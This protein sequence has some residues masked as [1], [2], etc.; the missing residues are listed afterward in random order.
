MA[1]ALLNHSIF[2]MATLLALATT[3]TL[4]SC[5][6]EMG[7]ESAQKAGNS[8]QVITQ[9]KSLGSKSGT[10]VLNSDGRTAGLGWQE[11]GA[12]KQ[13]QAIFTGIGCKAPT[14]F[15]AWASECGF[16]ENSTNKWN[17]SAILYPVSGPIVK[18]A[19]EPQSPAALV[20]DGSSVLVLDDHSCGSRSPSFSAALIFAA[21]NCGLNVEEKVASWCSSAPM[22]SGG[23]GLQ[24]PDDLGGGGSDSNSNGNEGLV[25]PEDLL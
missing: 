19:G 5:A 24:V 15:G 23:E 22:Q 4:A 11:E 10:L 8:S 3:Q 9:C 18:G 14:T 17:K 6:A 20:V 21:T 25:V 2:F 16:N 12:A 13:I 7:E 1:K